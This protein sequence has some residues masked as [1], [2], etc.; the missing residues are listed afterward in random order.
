MNAQPNFT[1]T[2]TPVDPENVDPSTETVKSLT[3]IFEKWVAKDA[4][5]MDQVM[6]ANE[7]NSIR[8][9]ANEVAMLMKHFEDEQ[10]KLYVTKTNMTG[11]NAKN[12]WDLAWELKK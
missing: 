4:K 7:I 10:L 2:I 5:F 3:E 9:S 6:E 1:P 11:V 8:I 12:G